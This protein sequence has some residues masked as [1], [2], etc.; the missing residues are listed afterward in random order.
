L[1]TL[2]REEV[3]VKL[4]RFAKEIFINDVKT[5]RDAISY[6]VNVNNP[7]WLTNDHLPGTSIIQ[8]FHQ[9]AELLF[10]E[11]N[12]DFDPQ[13]S[14]FFAGDIRI[15]F[16]KPIFEG[17]VVTFNVRC[18]RFMANV[19]LFRGSCVDSSGKAYARASGSLS[20][21]KRAEIAVQR[22]QSNQIK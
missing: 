1:L 3:E 21:K 17:H 19:L 22:L 15:K 14:M 8:C 9:G 4:S 7:E 16:L 12:E 11:N 2:T 13:E 20:S 10:Y 6:V 5:D 18:E